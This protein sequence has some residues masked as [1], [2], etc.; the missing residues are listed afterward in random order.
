MESKHP[1]IRKIV[2]DLNDR[3]GLHLSSLDEDIQC[4]IIA[5][6]DRWAQEHDRVIAHEG[7]GW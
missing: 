7:P 5:L 1:L 4:E 2:D 3:L 6:W